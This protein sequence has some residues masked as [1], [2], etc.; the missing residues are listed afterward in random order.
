MLCQIVEFLYPKENLLQASGEKFLNGERTDWLNSLLLTRLEI[1]FHSR[2]NS[3][4]LAR[5]VHPNGV[6]KR[7]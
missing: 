2:K 5:N 6:T 4:S 1:I 3:A 7:P